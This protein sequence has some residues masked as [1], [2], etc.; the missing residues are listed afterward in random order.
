M[1]VTVSLRSGIGRSSN[2][3]QTALHRQL[4][5][6]I[7]VLIQLSLVGCVSIRRPR[8][9]LDRSRDPAIVSELQARLAA[10]PALGA[11]SFR[12]EAHGGAVHLHGA[13]QGIGGW[14]CALRNAHLVEGVATVIDYL[15]IERGPRDIECRAPRSLD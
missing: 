1:K 6:G 13:V 11:S 5:L 2:R 8:P 9:P 12:V 10:E 3:A 15:V 4:L 7:L 14:S